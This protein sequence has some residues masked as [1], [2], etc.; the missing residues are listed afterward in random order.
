M[1][2]APRDDEV[3]QLQGKSF[4]LFSGLLRMAHEAG[5]QS[6]TTKLLQPPDSTNGQ[7]AIVEATVML[8]QEGDRPQVYTALGDAGQSTTRLTAYVRMAETRAVARAL[9]WALNIGEAAAEELDEEGPVPERRPAPQQGRW[10]DQPRRQSQPSPVEGELRCTFEG[11]GVELTA[12]QA[13][14]S[15]KK[16]SALLCPRH[17]VALS[18]T[19]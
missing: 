1:T 11:C 6:I 18:R 10:R 15:Q 16:C 5:L 19:G 13:L 9:R 14:I 3:I 4:V 8:Q 17:Q 12:N 2:A 7:T